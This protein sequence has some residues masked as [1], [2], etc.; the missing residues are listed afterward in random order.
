MKKNKK[1]TI[2]ISAAILLLVVGGWY[3]YSVVRNSWMPSR[4]NM[5]MAI[6]DIYTID[7]VAQT[8][9]IDRQRSDHTMENAYHTIFSQYGMSKEIYD[10]A[11]AVYSKNPEQYALLM[12]DVVEILASREAK[13][14]QLYQKHDSIKRRINHLNDSLRTSYWKG[15][16]YIRVPLTDKD[17]T[18][19]KLTFSYKTKKIKGGTVSYTFDYTVLRINK[20]EDPAHASLIVFYEGGESDT[21][22]AELLKD[23]HTLQHMTIEH[24]LRDT[25]HAREFRICL[26]ETKKVQDNNVNFSS[27]KLNYMPYEITDS[28]QFDEV[29]LPKIFTY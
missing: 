7:A 21:C 9:N 16:S 27:I 12:E 11:L 19:R 23:N 22:R 2:I 6:S 17:T 26:M 8:G 5:I 1:A 25:V 29:Q 14:L 28:V 10:S 15:S 20:N 18:N 24:N 4:H 3:L 13:F